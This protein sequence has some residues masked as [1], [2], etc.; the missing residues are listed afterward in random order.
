MI[1][2]YEGP[3]AGSSG[4]INPIGAPQGLTDSDRHSGTPQIPTVRIYNTDFTSKIHSANFGGQDAGWMKPSIDHLPEKF[5][6][7]GYKGIDGGFELGKGY[8]PESGSNGLTGLT[9]L[10]ALSRFLLNSQYIGK[11]LP[12]VAYAFA[13]SKDPRFSAPAFKTSEIMNTKEAMQKQLKQN[14]KVASAAY[15]KSFNTAVRNIKGVEF[16]QLLGNIGA[17]CHPEG[18]GFDTGILLT[19]IQNYL[20]KPSTPVSSM[21]FWC[22][23]FGEPDLIPYLEKT[24]L[25]QA[26]VEDIRTMTSLFFDQC[27]DFVAGREYVPICHETQA[28]IL[29]VIQAFCVSR[30][31]I[32]PHSF[33]QLNLAGKSP[34]ESI[35]ILLSNEGIINLLCESEYGHKLLR[36]LKRFPTFF[37]LINFNK[38][39]EEL[40]NKIASEE[41]ELQQLN[42]QNVIRRVLHSWS[43]NRRG[44][45]INS[46]KRNRDF[47]KSM[48]NEMI[49]S[50][51]LE[52]D[53]M[54]KIQNEG[55][56]SVLSWLMQQ[57]EILRDRVCGLINLQA[58]SEQIAPDALADGK[59]CSSFVQS[60][61][62]LEI[63][64]EFRESL[65]LDNKAFYQAMAKF[66]THTEQLEQ[67]FNRNHIEPE[68]QGL[69]LAS[70]ALLPDLTRKERQRQI[71]QLAKFLHWRE[72]LPDSRPD[73][74]IEA[75]LHEAGR[76]LTP[77]ASYLDDRMRHD[78]VQWCLMSD[79]NEKFYQQLE[80]T[81]KAD[82]AIE[83]LAPRYS[84]GISVDKNEIEFM[85]NKI[86]KKFK[87]EL[88]PH[89]TK[90]KVKTTMLNTMLS[91][92]KFLDSSTRRAWFNLELASQLGLWKNKLDVDLSE[93]KLTTRHIREH[94]PASA[95]NLVNKMMIA[96]SDHLVVLEQI[97]SELL[98][99]RN[100]LS[101]LEKYFKN[102]PNYE[103]QTET[104]NT[105]VT[106]MEN[107]LFTDPERLNQFRQQIDIMFN[108]PFITHFTERR[109]EES[110][111]NEAIR[112]EA[113]ICAEVFL[114]LHKNLLSFSP[115]D[116]HKFFDNV[117]TGEKAPSED[118]KKTLLEE[119][120]TS[121]FEDYNNRNAT[122]CTILSLLLHK[123]FSSD[124]IADL[125]PEQA[126]EKSQQLLTALENDLLTQMSKLIDHETEM[127]LAPLT[128]PKLENQ[129][130]SN[131]TRF[132]CDLVGSQ[133]H[134]NVFSATITQFLNQHEPEQTSD[135]LTES[136]ILQ[137]QR[138]LRQHHLNGREDNDT[139]VEN[140]IE[141]IRKRRTW[142]ELKQ[143][144]HAVND[145]K[146]LLSLRNKSKEDQSEITRQE[147][148][149][150]LTN[151]VN[152][153][154]H[155]F[156]K[157]ELEEV[158]SSTE[159]AT[160]PEDKT[161]L[162]DAQS[163]VEKVDKKHKLS[164]S[165]MFKINQYS[166]TIQ[167]AL[168]DFRQT[169]FS[170]NKKSLTEEV[171][172]A[173]AQMQS[174]NHI[175]GEMN[176][177]LTS[178]YKDNQDQLKKKMDEIRE[179]NYYLQRD[180]N[181]QIHQ[182]LQEH[183]ALIREVEWTNVGL[184]KLHDDKSKLG[185]PFS[186]YL[187]K[188]SREIPIYMA[189]KVPDEGFVTRVVAKKDG[190]ITEHSTRDDLIKR[191][192]DHE[193]LYVVPVPRSKY[194]EAKQQEI[195]ESVQSE[196][197]RRLASHFTEPA[198]A[199][200]THNN[201][202]LVV[203]VVDSYRLSKV[204]VREQKGTNVVF[205]GSFQHNPIP[206]PKKV[207]PP[208][209][210]LPE[211]VND[212]VKKYINAPHTVRP[213]YN[214]NRSDRMPLDY[215]H[216]ATTA[217]A[218]ASPAI[219]VPA[220]LPPASPRTTVASIPLAP[221]AISLATLPSEAVFPLAAPFGIPPVA[222]PSASGISPALPS[223]ASLQS[224]VRQYDAVKHADLFS[225]SQS[226]LPRYDD[227][228]AM[229]QPATAAS[230]LPEPV[231]QLPDLQSFQHLLRLSPASSSGAGSASSTTVIDKPAAQT[232][233][234]RS[235]P[236]DRF[237]E[238][239]WRAVQHL[240]TDEINAPNFRPKMLKPDSIQEY[241]APAR[242]F[243]I[244][245]N[246]P[247]ATD[248][249]HANCMLNSLAMH[250]SQDYRPESP[251]NLTLVR[252]LREKL[253]EEWQGK[254]GGFGAD[255]YMSTGSG[256]CKAALH[257]FNEKLKNTG[258]PEMRVIFHD[259]LR[260]GRGEYLEMV[261]AIGP[262]HGRVV[263]ILQH[264]SHF[265]ALLRH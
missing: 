194:N 2:D 208:D 128:G 148:N 63:C 108:Y 123:M 69:L 169:A 239:A 204:S 25:G 259:Y 139:F 75:Y 152:K 244:I 252:D 4:T 197:N 94:H 229:Q 133:K 220:A 26:V 14:A 9:G 179:A 188:L 71:G 87:P 181:N 31:G 121:L 207:V 119:I 36:Q 176:F 27:N 62:E 185:T 146:F 103:Q 92:K 89:Q 56:D 48:G 88:E 43:I 83:N 162:S 124:C 95:D 198:T 79:K 224:A 203:P 132:A 261:E 3:I 228:P 219:F 57:D 184:H 140:F 74:P 126:A 15:S 225:S 199:S 144:S 98:V 156:F 37:N 173:Y 151:R 254:E 186:R 5:N 205:A 257:Y 29:G 30:E 131:K 12:P 154:N 168:H 175:V 161:S 72:N 33:C 127:T 249:G 28:E 100:S 210:D 80:Q 86:I 77:D 115:I 209:L 109:F 158:T 218:A 18:P 70:G 55:V 65:M 58:C 192:P 104:V 166:G 171:L 112:Q 129:N 260:V 143:L 165:L 221:D 20:D 231:S 22:H 42:S 214:V 265:T 110:V 200:W 137:L 201:S 159:G 16:P 40:D 182:N 196:H 256:S 96:K 134:S 163:F 8:M 191:G 116:I 245:D 10:T 227:R 235:A 54:Q 138:A 216:H 44:R 32:N 122:T 81:L 17:I 73:L 177:R 180:R 248:T 212:L 11:H 113:E 93:I 264:Q 187:T 61:I 23:L 157:Q 50:Q 174:I 13:N 111:T 105:L 91:Q 60:T 190:K 107:T 35:A 262:I 237:G 78:M 241:I 41:Q 59:N 46:L 125:P 51:Q 145:Y 135:T 223:V 130:I 6:F 226:H 102:I 64:G 258:Q 118:I 211:T 206:A 52:F 149:Q 142:K 34:E 53:V 24:T 1:S 193:T 141:F 76:W 120:R 213:V 202:P 68:Q 170:R 66:H 153:G 250:F 47:K 234:E 106:L 136:E 99:T 242:E 246:L 263:H 195:L 19:F 247:Y 7:E 251:Q 178:Q 101:T 45:K 97:L 67:F 230:F 82:F 253:I 49:I 21:R 39:I 38:K 85:I 255:G 84:K 217:E 160:Q 167:Q 236:N 243:A 232:A 114:S 240:S 233:F 164:D 222:Q 155:A 150:N 238:S 117:T 90:R 147:I 215:Y 172:L 189:Y 183:N